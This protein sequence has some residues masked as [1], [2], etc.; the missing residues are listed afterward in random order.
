MAGTTV[1]VS[2]ITFNSADSIY[3]YFI[4]GDVVETYWDTVSQVFTVKKNGANYPQAGSSSVDMSSY[5]L[6][7]N[8]QFSSLVNFSAQLI[9]PYS[10][11]STTQYSFSFSLPSSN[12]AI[13]SGGANE[14]PYVFV[15]Q[16][17]GA[18]VCAV[19]PV[20][21]DLAWTGLPIVTNATNATSNDGGIQYQATSSYGPIQY[22]LTDFLVGPFLTTPQVSTLPPGN[23]TWFARDQKGFK[24]S[25][26]FTVWNI[27]LSNPPPP[28]QIP[29]LQFPGTP[30]ISQDTGSGNGSITFTA[31]SSY[32]PI[33]YALR[34]FVY[35]DGNGQASST[36][37]NLRAGTYTLYATDS[38]RAKAN[39]PFTIP[40][41]A[42]PVTPPA[43]A[44]TNNIIYQLRVADI[45][46]KF[47]V[48][49]II[50]KGYTG[51]VTQIDPGND[52]PIVYSQRLEGSEDKYPPVGFG[53]LQVCI[54][55]ST[56]FQFGEFLTTDND[57]YRAQLYHDGALKMVGK[58]APQSYKEPYTEG[59]N[60]PVSLLVV[61]GLEELDNVDFTDGSGARI[62]GQQKAISVIAQ[63]LAKLG[64]G[65]NIRVGVNMYATGMNTTSA[66]DPLDQAYVDC[67]SYYTETEA[68]SCT[69]VIRRIITPFQ[70]T[71]TQWG[72]YWWIVRREEMIASFD[73]REFDYNG[74]YKSNTNYNPISFIRKTEFPSSRLAWS[75]SAT[76]DTILPQ[77]NI[78]V[79]YKQG[80]KKTL[81]RNGEF[82]IVKKSTPYQTPTQSVDLTGFTLSNNGDTAGGTQFVSV[83]GSETNG[84]LVLTG[85]GKAYLISQIN[86]FRFNGS[87]KLKVELKYKTD[88]QI[89]SFR[90]QRVRM[91]IV[92]FVS[93]INYYLQQDGSWTNAAAADLVIY[94]KEPGKYK[95]FNLTSISPITS[96][97]TGTLSIYVYSSY[98]LDAEFTSTAT[99]KAKTTVGISSQ[100]RTEYNSGS[101]LYYYELENNTS[102]ESLPSASSPASS[103]SIVRPNDYNAVTNPNQWI[104]K[105][106]V[107]YPAINSGSLYIDEVTIQYQPNGVDLIDESTESLSTQNG[108]NVLVKT[109]Y[110]GSAT[111]MVNTIFSPGFNIASGTGELKQ[112]VSS[113][114]NYTTTHINYFRKSDG[115]PWIFWKRDA[116]TESDRLQR[117]H[118]KSYAAQYKSASRRITGTLTNIQIAPAIA[119]PYITP[120]TMLKETYDNRFYIPQGYSWDVCNSSFYGEFIEETDI[121]KGGTTTKSGAN[122]FNRTFNKTFR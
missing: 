22:D 94:E 85:T 113:N 23:Y 67:N 12:I 35:G 77:G 75:D 25:F 92:F 34:D 58:I 118:L 8:T 3:G 32:P 81:I 10:C 71:I 91:R 38:I 115:T 103:A 14:W 30:T 107:V 17:P 6:F 53:Q 5:I 89:S 87:D 122:T 82:F 73:Y 42:A 27:A 119:P 88:E 111:D 20:I 2:R 102:A 98:I 84:A 4:Q 29:D 121:T 49:N 95:T 52:A 68:L 61:D 69:E 78:Q 63:C 66:D 11:V 60:Y 40:L 109:I 59:V 46:K 105:G 86:S 19:T 37:S 76:L 99:M 43:T 39:Y 51:A 48:L 31:T 33:Q 9:T 21:Q 62:Y 70:A 44:P 7:A 117:I 74:A 56:P 79:V 80:L 18:N 116:V 110:H 108:K 90:Y 47:A 114:G 36:F 55:S 101:I 28:V 104:Q 65:L 83:D 97:N 112:Q 41:N 13:F 24:I 106:Q 26:A 64:F 1:L 16:T 45:N 93:G 100:S 72:G 57:T 120:V 15:T 96:A 50:K 54:N